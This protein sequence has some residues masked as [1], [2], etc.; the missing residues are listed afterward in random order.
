MAHRLLH[1]SVRRQPIVADRRD[2]PVAWEVIVMLEPQRPVTQDSAT[3]TGLVVS[4]LAVMLL[5]RGTETL[6]RWLVD[7][8]MDEARRTAPPPGTIR[9][10]Q[11]RS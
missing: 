3:R 8:G 10:R 9:R 2:D 7:L 5:A 11:D 1:P 6:A 4:A